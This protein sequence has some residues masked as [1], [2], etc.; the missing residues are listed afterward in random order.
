[1]VN[2]EAGELDRKV[3]NY[4]TA[5]RHWEEVLLR[6]HFINE[7]AERICAIPL[8]RPHLRR[9]YRLRKAWGN[10]GRWRALPVGDS[11]GEVGN[12]YA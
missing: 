7:L 1:M 11:E 3:S 4:I 5:G 6:S 9:C 12:I 8:A 2:V 10:E